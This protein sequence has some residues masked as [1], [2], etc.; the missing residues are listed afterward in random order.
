MPSSQSP[1]DRT[2]T[3]HLVEKPRLAFAPRAE[4]LAPHFLDRQ[5]QMGNQSLVV[6]RLGARRRQLRVAGAQ[7]AL[8][9]LDIVRKRISRAHRP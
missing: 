6:R 1:S 9:R 5:P 3:L 4:K 8:Q 7:Q 2:L